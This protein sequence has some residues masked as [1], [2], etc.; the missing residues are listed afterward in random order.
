MPPKSAKI[1]EAVEMSV[2]CFKENVALSFNF[3]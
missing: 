2:F 1:V 3:I